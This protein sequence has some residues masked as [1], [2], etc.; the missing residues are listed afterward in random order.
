MD[1][2]KWVGAHVCTLHVVVAKLWGTC[3][4]QSWLSQ[5]FVHDVTDIKSSPTLQGEPMFVVNQGGVYRKYLAKI[6]VALLVHQFYRLPTPKQRLVQAYEW[7][8]RK[9]CTCIGENL[10]T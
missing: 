3:V 8:S 9:V 6:I 7:R 5:Y 1:A 4:L 10:Y 2:Y